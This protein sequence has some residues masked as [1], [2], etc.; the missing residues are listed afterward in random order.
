MSRASWQRRIPFKVDIAGIIEIM[1]SSLYSRATT[2]I[3]ELIQNAHDGI[4]RRRQGD[5][6]FK[7]KIQ[8]AQDADAGTVTF[9]DDGIGL[10]ADEAEKYLGTLGVGITGLIK[11]STGRSSETPADAP[12]AGARGDGSTLIG[13]FGIG[14][15]SAFMLADK[16]VVETRRVG[17]DEDEGVRWEAGVGSDVEMAGCV[18]PQIGTSVTLHLKSKYANLAKSPQAI[19]EAVKEYADFLPL[20]IYLNGSTA[21]VN[22]INAAWFDPTPD[23]ETI[24]LELESLFQETALDVISIHRETPASIAGTL[25]VTPQRTPGFSSEAVVTAT[26]RRMVISRSIRNLLPPWASF[27]RGVLE[28]NGCAPTASR[29]DLVRDGAFD[30]VRNMLE[31]ILFEHF[32]AIAEKDP[33]RLES[34]INWHRYTL[35]GAALSNVRLRNLLRKSYPFATSQGDLT[36]DQ[37]LAKSP[38]DAV[39]EA[40]AARVIWYNGDRRQEQWANTLFASQSVPCVHALRSFEEGLLAAMA[41][42]ASSPQLTPDTDGPVAVRPASPSSPNFARSVLGMRDMHEAPAAWDA[43]LSGTGAKIF[44]AR[45]DASQPVMAFLNEKRE[46]MQTF[47][48]L[49]KTGEIPSGFQRLIDQ[50]FDQNKPPQNEVVLNLAHALVKNALAQSSSHPLASVLRLLVINALTSAG[51]TITAEVRRQQAGDL[52]WIAQTIGAR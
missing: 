17:S 6:L 47:E 31:D 11:K 13:Q 26:V 38:A 21:R 19:E 42:D 39:F 28:L 4:M 2:P 43:F 36:F 50:H 32:E 10:S 20:P 27:V 22:V 25:Y 7:G 3:R 12:L 40:E 23:R 46:L 35:A 44:V 34:V 33:K 15:F 51:A 5:L 8:I 18:R 41:G 37:V 24:E 30:Q 9:T 52:D 1:G 16:L 49:K 48:R 45:F 14:L 29:E